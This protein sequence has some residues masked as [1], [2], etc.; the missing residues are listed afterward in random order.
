MTHPQI[1]I[2]VR[3]TTRM[4]MLIEYFPPLSRWF[5]TYFS[6]RFQQVCKILCILFVLFPLPTETAIL[7]IARM[8]IFCKLNANKPSTRRTRQ[9]TTYLYCASFC[10]CSLFINV[11]MF[12]LLLHTRELNSYYS[13][14]R[15]L[16]LLSATKF[17]WSSLHLLQ[18]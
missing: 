15:F 17:F 8:T 12:S 4:E 18:T 3:T 6:P 16:Q 2:S 1:I 11:Y 14:K 5:R 7:C 9:H 10:C 13:W